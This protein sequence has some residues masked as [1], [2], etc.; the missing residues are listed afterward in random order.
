MGI[1]WAVDAIVGQTSESEDGLGMVAMCSRRIAAMSAVG[2]CESGFRGVKVPGR[3]D[4]N[5]HF[6][7]L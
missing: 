1:V 2:V 4:I 5:Q 6:P 7:V 3:I